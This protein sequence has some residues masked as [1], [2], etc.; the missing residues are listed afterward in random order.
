MSR[1]Y[2]RGEINKAFEKIKA[3]LHA[4]AVLKGRGIA[5]Y[6]DTYTGG[7]LWGGDSYDYDH[8]FPSELIHTKYKD[9]FSDQEIAE[10]VNIR[11]NIAVTLRSINQSKGKKNPEI[12]IQEVRQTRN[13][14]IKVD[15]VEKAIQ[16]AK[17]A[18]EKKKDLLKGK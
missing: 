3:Q 7:K 17:Q 5:F 10:I 16:H 14:S 4:E 8:I 2:H 11:E 6:L 18:I 1:P 15:L 13:E 9:E 12:W